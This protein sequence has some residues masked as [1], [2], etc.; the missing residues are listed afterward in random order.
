[1][2]KTIICI[3][4]GAECA[5]EA[6]N[7]PYCGSTLPAG[8]EKKY[9]EQLMDVKD[10]LED[11][12][13]APL[14]QTKA[15]LRSQGKVLKIGIL[16]GVIFLVIVLGGAYLFDRALH[17]DEEDFKQQYLWKQEYYPVMDELYDKGDFDGLTRFF[18]EHMEDENAPLYSWEHYHFLSAYMTYHDYA[19]DLKEGEYY[20]SAASLFAQ[21]WRAKG[22]LARPDHYTEAEYAALLP[23][24]EVLE[25]DYQTRWNIDPAEEQ[26]LY[27]ELEAN[28]YYF[29][30][31][32]TCEK[33]AKKWSKEN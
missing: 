29:L 11:L 14:E 30:H 12:D 25:A 33:Y 7:C 17:R 27:Q 20:G 18:E 22:D 8:A 28:D 32:D 6:A 31:F 10:R 19:T 13:A 2:A 23:M 9:M 26:L 5:E 15:A 4:C 24:L 3:S 16:I 1:M 21:Q